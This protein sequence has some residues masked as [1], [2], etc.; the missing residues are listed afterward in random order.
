MKALSRSDAF[1]PAFD[2]G[3]EFDTAAIKITTKIIG[4]LAFS[5]LRPYLSRS[6]GLRQGAES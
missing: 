5:D 4:K 6:S 2:S 1:D 3:R